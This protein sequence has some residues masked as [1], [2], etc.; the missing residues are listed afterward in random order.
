M[1]ENKEGELITIPLDL[2]ALWN[3]CHLLLRPGWS[4]SAYKWLDTKL[5]TVL[6]FGARLLF[7]VSHLSHSSATTL[8]SQ[9][10][11]TYSKTAFSPLY[12]VE[13]SALNIYI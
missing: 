5:R 10:S 13:I 6:K 1:A 7:I 2:I 9:D 12:A 11:H 4:I 8:L 3:T